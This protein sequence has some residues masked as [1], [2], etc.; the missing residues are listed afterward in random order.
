MN[1]GST[2]TGGGGNNLGGGGNGAHDN[3]GG[4]TGDDASPTSSD[5][6]A[7]D[8]DDD[9]E[10]DGGGGGVGAA[11]AAVIGVCGCIAAVGFLAYKRREQDKNAGPK[12]VLPDG[13]STWTDEVSGAPC[14]EHTSGITQWE[15]PEGTTYT[16]AKPA[17]AIAMTTMFRNPLKEKNQP[18]AAAAGGLSGQGSHARMATQLPT[19]W[20]TDW[21]QEGNKYCE[22]NTRIGKLRWWICM[23]VSL[24]PDST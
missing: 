10:G 6:D 23:F 2:S 22:C 24:L 15:V 21:D 7:S 19:D 18:K 17:P 16:N 20:S 5:G 12:M 4:D 8:P 14:Y 11:V 1:G 13:W 9:G 3:A